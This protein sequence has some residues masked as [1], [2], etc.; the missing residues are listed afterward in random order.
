MM[1]MKPLQTA[2]RAPAPPSRAQDGVALLE[3]LIAT[4]ILAIGLLGAIG[5]QARAYSALSDASMRA[6]ATIA[7][8]RLLGLMALDQANLSLYAYAGSGTVNAKLAGWVSETRAAIP[9]ASVT[10]VV[11]PVASTSRSQIDIAI[12]WQRKQGS[13]ASVHAVTSYIANSK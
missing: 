12:G 5:M 10:V 4:L 2:T 7:S 13:L 1:P 11:A 6:E 3:A 9:G 8:E